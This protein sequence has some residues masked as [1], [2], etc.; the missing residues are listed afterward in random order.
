MA[1]G[2]TKLV[3]L[4]ILQCE[5]G[6]VLIDTTISLISSVTQWFLVNF[7]KSRLIAKVGSQPDK[8]LEVSNKIK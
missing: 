2:D 5:A 4:P 6:N 7:G 1:K 3:G 8:V